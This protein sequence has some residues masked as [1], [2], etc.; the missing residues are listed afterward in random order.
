MKRSHCLTRTAV[1]LISLLL[2]ACA[3]KPPQKIVFRPVA[4]KQAPKPTLH[5]ASFDCNEADS[6]LQDVICGDDPLATLDRS[7]AEAYRANLRALDLVGRMQLIGNQRRWLLSRTPQ[8][9]VQGPRLGAAKPNPAQVA[10]L[11]ANY[12]ARIAELRNWPQPQA[13]KPAQ[14]KFHPLGAYVEFRLVEARDPA[15]CSDMM[16][17]FND[18]IGDTGAVDFTR[19]NG[20]TQIAGTHGPAAGASSGGHR[21]DV[22]LYDAGLY[23]S[24]QM[25][26]NGLH[27]NGNSQINDLSLGDWISQTTNAGGRFSNIS[28]Q[29]RDYGTLDIFKSGQ[30]HFALVSETWGYYSAAARGESAYA[31]LYEVGNGS[32]E[33]RCLYTIYLTPPI[34]R[35]FDNMPAYQELSAALN[36]MSGELVLML[37]QNE[38]QDEAQL[39]RE[40]EWTLLNMPLVAL[41]DAERYGRFGALRQRHDAALEAI[42]NWSERNVPSKLH[43][44]RLMPLIQ[45]AHDQLVTIF[46]KGQGLKPEEATAAADLML[47]D[48]IDRAAELLGDYTVNAPAPL[49]P[50]ASYNPRYAPAPAPGDLERG[51]RLTTLHSALINRA[52]PETIADFI[53]YDFASPDRA[54]GIGPA[55]NT[56]LMAAVRTPEA[57]PLLLSTGIDVNATNA[58][59][60][61]ALMTAAQTNQLASVQA[62]L[63]AGANVNAATIA[64]Y[65][66]GAGG[67][68]NAEGSISGRTALM[69]AAAGANAEVVQLLLARGANAAA[70]DGYGGSACG[71]LSR[72]TVMQAEEKAAVTSLLCRN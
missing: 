28:S 20:F 36:V 12:N 5:K 13:R 3:S 2:A 38:R 56:A 60:K 6:T 11:K 51:R 64:W 35:A 44:R 15:I 55:G 62:L 50:F 47:I 46:Q 69:Y 49:P 4:S 71:Y 66:E 29:T 26:A 52:G 17:R 34:A 45:P 32:A 63:D 61:T 53:K 57:I 72:N 24:Y 42:F 16:K 54:Q 37:S 30:R 67:I 10:C 19:M 41:A 40:T 70:Q 59:K 68:D 39:Q 8:C 14:A 23:A 27:I 18:A 22:Q 1:L 31:G 43:Y 25:R 48:L 7:M 21:Y 33:A 58:W 65:Q 9:K